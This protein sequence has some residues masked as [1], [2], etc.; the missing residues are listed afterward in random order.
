MTA[1]DLPDDAPPALILAPGMMCDAASWAP[2]RAALDGEA[3]LRVARYGRARTLAG[4]AEALLADAPPRFA[5]A[6]H[7]MGGRV[8]MEVARLA[9]GRLTGLCL[10]G[11]DP[12]P[13]PAG[14]AGLAESRAR[15]HLLDLARER[16]MAAMADRFLP[17][18]VHPE[19]LGEAGLA[20]TIRAMIERQDP[21]ALARQIAAGEGRPDHRP[22]LGGVAAPALVICGAE[23]GFGRAPLQAAMAAL[24]PDAVLLLIDRCGHLPML[25]TPD[26][27]NRAMSDWLARVRASARQLETT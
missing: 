3:D 17:G 26:T 4:M 14:E 5:I 7:S 12:L 27:V 9:P 24:L 23:D 8:A 10:I 13:K 22:V 6:G 25:E 11:A 18:L 1:F 19:R 2:Q 15:L 21:E 20:G 16:G